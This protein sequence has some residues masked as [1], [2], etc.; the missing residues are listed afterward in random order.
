MCFSLERSGRLRHESEPREHPGAAG[1]AHQLQE[2]EQRL[3]GIPD[4][5]RELH[6]EHAARKTEIR[7]SRRRPPRRPGSGGR[8]KRR[9]RTPR[10]SSRSTSSR[11][12][13][14]APS[15]ST[16]PCSRRS[17]PSRGRSPPTRSRPSRRSSSTR[18][19]RRSSPPC[20]RASARS[21][22][23]TPPR[24]PAGRRR[25][26]AIAA[27]GRDA[28][29]PQVAE[30]KERLPRGIV[31]QFER[32]LERYPGGAMAPVRLIER[33]GQQAARVAL[34]APATTGCAPRWWS[35]SATAAAWSSA[36]PASASS[37]FPRR[38][39]A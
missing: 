25:S 30:L 35:R 26:P 34:R 16:A 37:I 2:A 20:A 11:S 17:T 29:R 15:A 9:S 22:S 19:R 38:S 36:T 5:M 18:R 24:W 12:T 8:R 13:R 7:P 21:R 27:A 23:A 39:E 32:I 10:K 1:G 31:A 3:H 33:P 6:E 4:W 28:R 14:S